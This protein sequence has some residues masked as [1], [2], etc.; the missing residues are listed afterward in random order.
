MSVEIF[1]NQRKGFYKIV[2]ISLHAIYSQAARNGESQSA[3]NVIEVFW[4][5]SNLLNMLGRLFSF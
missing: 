1:K 3:H 2:S 4:L 5:L